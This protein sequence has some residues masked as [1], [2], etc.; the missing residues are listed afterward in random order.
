[1]YSRNNQ[2]FFSSSNKQEI[3][4]V[5]QLVNTDVTEQPVSSQ[6][7]RTE[8]VARGSVEPTSIHIKQPVH[9]QP[10]EIQQQREAGELAKAAEQEAT[11]ATETTPGSTSQDSQR[12]CL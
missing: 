2:E 9:V 8:F 12:V 6:P 11:G 1:M 4:I 10:H 3:Q 7:I 5:E